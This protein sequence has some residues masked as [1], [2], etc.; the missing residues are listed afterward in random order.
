M[1]ARSACPVQPPDDPLAVAR[2]E[3]MQHGEDRRDPDTGRDQNDRAGAVIEDEIAP[4]RGDVQRVS[5]PQILVQVAAGDAMGLLLDADPVGAAVW[6]RGQRVAAD[7]DRLPGTA[8]PQREVLAGLGGRQGGAVGGCE[9]D[10]GHVLGFADHLGDAQLPEAGPGRFRVGGR[11]VGRGQQIAE[12]ALPARAEGGYV[13]GDAQLRLVAVREIEQRVR[14]GHGQRTGTGPGLDDRVA[15]LDASFGDNAHVEA[16]PVM[17]H[18]QYGQFRLAKPHAYPVA[19]DAGLGDLELRLADA[20]P[21]ADADLVIEHAVYGQVLAELAIGKLSAPEVLPPV[22]V[23]LNL[24]DEHGPLLAAVALRVALAVAVDVEAAHH[25]RPGDGRLP[26]T[27]VNGLAMPRHVLWHPDIDRQ[28]HRSLANLHA[29]A[30]HMGYRGNLT[31][32]F[33]PSTDFPSKNTDFPS[34]N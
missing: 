8:Y 21:V 1:L 20:V 12:R 31:H 18:Q 5:W 19:G 13:Q 3:L 9:I 7:R 14:V 32:L 6:R 34:K 15:C 29:P 30:F 28:Q 24:V 22:L 10:R 2:G 4:G 11:S 33:P 27:R 17:A 25:P 16:G 26:H 23:G